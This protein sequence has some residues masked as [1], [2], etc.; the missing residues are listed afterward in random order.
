MSTAP[1]PANKYRAFCRLLLGKGSKSLALEAPSPTTRT[2]TKNSFLCPR[3]GSV[4]RVKIYLRTKGF[5]DRSAPYT[6]TVSD[7]SF[8]Y[9]SFFFKKKKKIYIYIYFADF[10]ILLALEFY[11]LLTNA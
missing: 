11:P 3:I 5:Q 8:P 4:P 10:L 1:F 9:F 2:G 7:N 6:R